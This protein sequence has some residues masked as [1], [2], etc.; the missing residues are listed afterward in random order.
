[1]SIAMAHLLYL[2][3]LSD[4]YEALSC[5]AATITT[6]ER[7]SKVLFGENHEE[8][9]LHLKSDPVQHLPAPILPSAARKAQQDLLACEETTLPPPP[10]EAQAPKYL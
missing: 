8:S 2:L 6:C 10:Y 9:C 3:H 7:R 4:D 5:R 1:M